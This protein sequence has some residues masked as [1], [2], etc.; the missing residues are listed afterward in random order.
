M[1]AEFLRR[2]WFD[3]VVL[4]DRGGGK[5]K[6]ILSKKDCKVDGNDSRSCP[7]S[8]S[9]T[10]DADPVVSAADV[11]RHVSMCVRRYTQTRDLHF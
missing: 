10:D 11:R 8:K 3:R 2:Y 1:H 7:T 6:P 9:G 5:L 4:D